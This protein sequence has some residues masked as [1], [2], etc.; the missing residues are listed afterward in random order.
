[1]R[2]HLYNSVYGDTCSVGQVGAAQR[3]IHLR[4]NWQ[5]VARKLAR[6]GRWNVVQFTFGSAIFDLREDKP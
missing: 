4:R 2:V 6:S 3:F 5:D 1:M